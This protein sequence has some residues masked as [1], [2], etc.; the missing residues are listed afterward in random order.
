MYDQLG[1]FYVVYGT[2]F[3]H[4]VGGDFYDLLIN[5]HLGK[6]KWTYTERHIKYEKDNQEWKYIDK[7]INHI[8]LDIDTIYIDGERIK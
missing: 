6:V 2:L 8:I 3:N 1:D 7:E 5:F 4:V